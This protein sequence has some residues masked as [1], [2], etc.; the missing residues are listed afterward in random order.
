MCRLTITAEEEAQ[1]A[2]RISAAKADPNSIAR[3]D[4][5]YEEYRQS[6][7]DEL[8]KHKGVEPEKA[9]RSIPRL[10]LH[11]REK[12]EATLPADHV[13]VVR[14][15]TLTVAEL[16][17][18]GAEL[19]KTAIPDPIEGPEYGATTAKFYWN[20]GITPRITSLAHGRQTLYRL[21][22][23]TK[24][25]VP[26]ETDLNIVTDL[27][28]PAKPLDP[29]GFP[30]TRESKSGITS[31]LSTIENYRHLLDGYGITAHYDPIKKA[32]MFSIPGH[33]GTAENWTNASITKI[34]SLAVLNGLSPT[35]AAG[36]LETIADANQVNPVLRWI[37]SKPWDG[38]DR[39]PALYATLTARDGFPEMLK[40][41][42]MHRWLLSLV[43]AMVKPTGFRARG[44]LTLQGKQG[45]GKTTWIAALV[46][47]PKLRDEYVLLGHHLDPGSKDSMTTAITHWI[48]ELGE[49][50]SSFKRD[51][52]RLKSFLTATM[53][54]VRRPYARTDSEYPRRTVFC[55]TVN[56]TTFLID[57]TGNTRFWTLPVVSINVDHGIDMQQ[58]YMQLKLEIERGEQWWLTEE[59]EALLDE[60]NKAFRAV[61]VVEERL[62]S[63]LDPDMPEE[64]WR[65]FTASEALIAVG[66]RQPS[67]PQCRE[68]GSVL[69]ARHGEPKKIR[70][71]MKWRLPMREY[72]NLDD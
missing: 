71:V 55:A 58:L 16:L 43:A 1:A 15:E 4:Q 24:S 21:Q 35:L 61:S 46:P 8:I 3:S 30:H 42:L 19:D 62:L 18:R 23:Q 12:Q 50:D 7:V 32:P 70:G 14:G 39:L 31:L 60:Q 49:L 17:Q 10:S 33:S 45:L 9:Q 65:W 38:Q 37:E 5:T 57:P 47:D 64:K 28:A 66:I 48:V 53:D 54:K 6:K 2:Q 68:A 56:E 29:E 63:G 11:G 34:V 59:E 26:T 44:V 36:Y 20:D 41:A 67:N 51:I 13:L 52:A 40:K 22:R 25:L 72:C 27:D 69:R